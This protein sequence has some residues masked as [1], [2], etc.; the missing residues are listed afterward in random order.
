MGGSDNALLT[1]VIGSWK[2][3]I[4]DYKKNK[5]MEDAVKQQEQQIQEFLAKKKEEAKG[6][7][8]RMN[9]AT[10]S[11][12]V[13]HVISTWVQMFKD[14]KEAAKMDELMNGG[15][16]RFAALNGRQKDNA[17]GVMSRVNEQMEL[18]CMLRHFSAWALDAKLER[19]MRHYNRKMES[20]KDQ[21]Q[22]VQ[23]LFS[24]FANQLDQGLKAGAGDSARGDDSGKR[25]DGSVSLP[26]IHKKS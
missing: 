1:V 15:N 6:V 4:A 9:S 20:K 26:S 25:Q 7:L 17:K 22:S 12:L 18:N 3:F 8:D 10:D 5:E 23:R 11:G 19:V 24:S 16:D 2:D 21:L 14:D 13:E